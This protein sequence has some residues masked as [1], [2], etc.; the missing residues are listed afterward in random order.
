MPDRTDVTAPRERLLLLIASSFVLCGVVALAASSQA[1]PGWPLLLLLP[2]FLGSFAFLHAVLCR[3]LPRRDP[4]LL[5]LCALLTGWGLLS[6]ARLAPRFLARQV[7]WVPISALAAA[8]AVCL[9]RDLRWLRRFRYTWLLGGLALL[10]TT[11]VIGV[12]PSGYGP[13]LW[14]GVCGV[15][16]QPSELLKLLMVVFLA[17]YLAEKRELL[18]SAGRTIGRVRL[19]P[20]A[21]IAPLL[22]MFGLAMVLLAWQQD[23]GAAML[24]FFTFLAVLYVAT[25]DRRYVLLS[26][27]LF[28]LLGLAGYA[29]SSRVELRVDAWL[30]PWREAADRSYQIVQSLYAFGAGGVFGQ[31]LGLGYPTY[32][33][34]VHTDFVFAAITE[35]YGLLGAL[36]VVALYTLI[37]W[38]GFGAAAR[39]AGPFQC[40]L[41][42]GLTSGLVIQ[43]WVIMAGNAKL[44]PIAG[45]TLPFVSYGG[46]SLLVSFITLALLL[47][48]SARD[49]EPATGKDIVRAARPTIRAAALALCAAL[50]LLGATCGYWGI[51]RA[52]Y[53]AGRGDNPRRVLYEER[54]VRG[55]IVDRAGSALAATEVAE[56]GTV[57]R[58]YPVQAAAPAV[59]YASLRYGTDGIEA[60]FDDRLRGEA[61]RS[62][63]EAAW[64]SLL[65]LPPQGSDLQLTIYAPLQVSAQELLLPYSGAVVL[66]E[67]SG[68]DILLLG[69]SPSFD[70]ATL[71]E[72]WEE[73]RDDPAAPLLNRAVRGL[74]QPGS[75]LQTVVLAEALVGGAA[76]LDDPVAGGDMSVRIDTASLGCAGAVVD[77]ATLGDAYRGACPAPFG[78][79]GERLGGGGLARAFERWLLTVPPSLEIPSEAAGWERSVLTSTGSLR[80]EAIGQGALTVSPLRMALVAAALG[81]DGMMPAPRL[82]TH[83]RHSEGDWLELAREGQPAQVLAPELAQALLRTWHLHRET[84]AGH[85][86]QAVSGEGREPHTWFLG[87][88]PAGDPRF[89]VVVLLEEASEAEPAAE[90]GVQLLETALASQQID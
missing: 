76:S 62:P 43:A 51:A 71:D 68:G 69:S 79:L 44:T 57:T 25:A 84:I 18:V 60:A 83:I 70:A 36:A 55:V 54:I 26:L 61:G 58:L 20:L 6:I 81:N 11:L 67:V 88:A 59:G 15:Y 24:F 3:H 39:A 34:A 49:T 90:I 29:L 73:L 78:D 40:F 19:P 32:I 45:V 42:S 85:L 5:P 77:P 75:A 9:S 22:V 66:L 47:R 4:Y 2:S 82:A 56:D 80:E 52:D 30:D 41:A 27:F 86:S 87:L 7:A 10:A 17:S 31:G 33:P 35:E 37:L 16:F 12:N 8:G 21:Y 1:H 46:S 38:R 50:I 28:V 63:W 72:D 89:A 53:L 74:Y 13:R 64:D 23:L 65:H 14:L 48:V